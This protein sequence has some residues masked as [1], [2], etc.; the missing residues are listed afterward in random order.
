MTSKNMLFFL[1]K[2]QNSCWDFAAATESGATEY[3][4]YM[5]SNN[6][7]VNPIT[8]RRC[9]KSHR[10]PRSSSFRCKGQSSLA[11]PIRG[12]GDSQPRKKG[13]AVSYHENCFCAILHAVYLRMNA[14]IGVLEYIYI[15]AC[16][17]IRDVSSLTSLALMHLND[18]N[19][20][21][22]KAF[23]EALVSYQCVILIDGF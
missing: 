17:F 19:N 4:Q 16:G 12:C 1:Q 3:D 8:L 14:A 23:A 18:T 20:N 5:H 2:D 11:S 6:E 13:Q 21:N 22:V 15:Q 7:I 10:K 9:P